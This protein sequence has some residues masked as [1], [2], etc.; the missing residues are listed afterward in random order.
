MLWRAVEARRVR[1]DTDLKTAAERVLAAERE[2]YVE[3][4]IRELTEAQR[5]VR[6]LTRAPAGDGGGSDDE[7]PEPAVEYRPVRWP[8]ILGDKDEAAQRWIDGLSPRWLDTWEGGAASAFAEDVEVPAAQ[9]GASTFAPLEESAAEAS[10][11]SRERVRAVVEQGMADGASVNEIA[12]RLREDQAW[13]PERALRVARTET[14]R[15][16]TAGTNARYDEAVAVGLEFEE[17]WLSDPSAAQWDRRHD[18]MDGVTVEPG[19]MFTL[20]DGTP[21]RGPGLSGVAGHDVN[22]RCGKSAKVR[23]DG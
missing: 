16:E 10:D 3:R 23:G 17:E 21:T 6:P 22:C 13:T 2:V 7:D 20:P 8:N 1:S 14:V 9:P 19:A 4:A 11:F 18:L 15:A 5:A 12:R